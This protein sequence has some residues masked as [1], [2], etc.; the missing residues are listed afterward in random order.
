M[1]GRN[2]T[3]AERRSNEGEKWA[4]KTHPSRFLVELDATDAV[5][6]VH[7]DPA[8]PPGA[9]AVQ[10]EARLDVHLKT[11]QKTRT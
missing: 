11:K 7:V 5:K 1:D 10:N 2:E 8:P 4:S 9:N 3:C 6:P